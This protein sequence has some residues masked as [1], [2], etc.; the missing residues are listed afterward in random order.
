MERAS[1]IQVKPKITT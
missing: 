1:M